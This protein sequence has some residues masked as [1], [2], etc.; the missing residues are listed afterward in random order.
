MSAKGS[1]QNRFSPIKVLSEGLLFQTWL[2]QDQVTGNHVVIK[3]PRPGAEVAAEELNQI[4]R[5]SHEAT[6]FWKHPGVLAALACY[7]RDGLA[8][9]ACRYVPSQRRTSLTPDVLRR[10]AVEI[11]PQLFSAI[12]FMHLMGYV[13]CDLKPENIFVVNDNGQNRILIVDLDFV[14]PIGAK[15]IGKII[16]T[17]PFIAPEILENDIIV[18]QSDYF[19][20]GV[21][22]YLLCHRNVGLREELLEPGTKI[23]LTDVVENDCDFIEDLQWLAPCV[24]TLLVRH[25]QLR[26]PRILPLLTRANPSLWPDRKELERSLF[27]H[28][29]RS[30]YRRFVA[31]NDKQDPSPAKFVRS[32]QRLFGIPR[33]ILESL[34]GK[35]SERSR[36]Q[37]RLL[38]KL[39]NNSDLGISAGRWS[40]RVPVES[41]RSVLERVMSESGAD[42]QK[43][44]QMLSRRQLLRRAVHLEKSGEMLAAAFWLEQVLQMLPPAQSS[45]LGAALKVRIARLLQK[46]RFSDAANANFRSLLELDDL[47]ARKKIIVLYG[48]ADGYRIS[49]S[50][51]ERWK[52]LG[53]AYGLARTLKDDFWRATIIVNMFWKLDNRSQIERAYR[54]LRRIEKSL[55]EL[56]TPTA[57]L[58]S[59]HLIGHLELRLGLVEEAEASIRLSLEEYDG[60]E[61]L[62]LL[63]AR[64]N[65]A[66][67]LFQLGRYK[68][69]YEVA[70]KFLRNPILRQDARRGMTHHLELLA[71][72]CVVGDYQTAENAGSD[73]LAAALA[74]NDTAAI[75]WQS[76]EVGWFYLR[77]GRLI[78]ARERLESAATAF[79]EMDNKHYLARSDILMSLLSSWKGQTDLARKL[80]SRAAGIFADEADPVN[81]LDARQYALQI[82]REEGRK[83]DVEEATEIINSYLAIGNRLGAAF[84]AS[85]LLLDREFA[86]VET[87]LKRNSALATFC[88]SSGAVIGKAVLLHLKAGK[89]TLQSSETNRQA[90]MRESLLFYRKYGYFYH[91]ANVALQLSEDYHK[92][93]KYQLARGFYSEAARLFAVLGNR[94]RADAAR[95]QIALLD[96][97][98]SSLTAKYHSIFE[99]SELLNSFEDYAVTTSKLLTFALEQTGAERAALLLATDGGADLR[100]ESAI[101]CDQVS[102]EDIVTMSKSVM[103][104]VFEKNEALIVTNAQTNEIT[105]EYR[106]VIKHN[107]Y[108]IACVP[109]LS[110]DGII[111][112]LYLDHH[113]LPS[114]FS[115]EERRLVEAVANFIAVALSRARQFDLSRRQTHELGVRSASQGFGDAFITRNPYLCKLLD[116]IPQVADSRAAILLLGES[117]TGKE[118]LANIIHQ[119]S[120]YRDGPLVVLNCAGLAGEVL[121]SELFGIEKGVATGVTRREGRIQSADGGTLFLDEIGDMPVAT[122]V[123][124]LRVIETREVQMIGGRNSRK[125]D[126]RL[127]AATHRDLAAMMASNGFRSDLYYRINTVEIMLPPLRERTDDLEPLIEHFAEVFAHG[128]KFKFSRSSWK[129]LNEY[130][131]P[132]NVRELR[133]FVERI[134]IQSVSDVVKEDLL[135][136]EVRRSNLKSEAIQLRPHIGNSEKALITTTLI[137]CN[138]NQSEAARHLGI[139]FSTIQ[140]KIKKLKIK[141][142]RKKH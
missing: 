78:E 118:V 64:A 50:R 89:A 83:V 48:L 3:R 132:G 53:Q 117:G 72:A 127:I 20:L 136:P 24:S 16:G 42:I 99:V 102:L 75:A 30:S 52:F 10:H 32:H 96:Q 91:A 45:T 98:G 135:P 59:A 33:E 26:P 134:S 17:K 28:D 79:E 115:A 1:S 47:P 46:A 23:D 133:N 141:V 129:L 8:E 11:L 114:V 18:P 110:G 88:R 82:D 93:G 71:V 69:A 86:V 97:A 100:I 105:R 138:G 70:L 85:L 14:R 94:N 34:E 68:E 55:K 35:L 90:P 37:L 57:R 67:V 29:Q 139:P 137:D 106:S 61:G 2:G 31:D 44:C 81:A 130:H 40:L 120:P 142:P 73:F 60:R 15:P 112:V 128:R 108:S 54:R 9:I 38:K 22:L 74:S 111:G 12:E 84:T 92:L 7:E 121:E 95:N 101:D 80:N 65:R 36:L 41:A 125:V 109:L 19:S 107:I 51:A 4:L 131:W 124:L 76:L 87:I 39:V 62:A 49:V 103:K 21:I 27:W 77:S 25:Y 116:G 5:D 126:F 119:H 123:K 122:Q 58:L 6:R 66:S 13:H 43:D 140:R 63:A 104:S 113:S 56:S